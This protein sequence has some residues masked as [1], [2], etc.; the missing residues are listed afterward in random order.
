MFLPHIVHKL[1]VTREWCDRSEITS[2]LFVFK[3]FEPCAPQQRS[4]YENTSAILISQEAVQGHTGRRGFLPCVSAFD[5]MLLLLY[6]YLLPASSEKDDITGGKKHT[7]LHWRFRHIIVIEEKG[8]Q[9]YDT[10]YKRAINTETTCK[11]HLLELSTNFQIYLSV[12]HFL[13]FVFL[14]WEWLA[15]RVSE[16]WIRV[17]FQP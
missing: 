12:A 16:K 15:R 1:E 14:W 3:T 8:T 17:C 7:R 6:L 9:N 2:F 10:K 4:L 5:T 11:I 13:A